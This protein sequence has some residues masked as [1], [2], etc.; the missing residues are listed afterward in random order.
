MSRRIALAGRV[1]A[2]ATRAEARAYGLRE[3]RVDV[4]DAHVAG[5]SMGGFVAATL[6]FARP[7]LV[8]SLL[9]SDAVGEGA[10]RAE[11]PAR[12]AADYRAFLDRVRAAEGPV[13]DARL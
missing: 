13:L 4:G 11:V 3:R 2:A 7:D 6:A 9:L 1:Y 12:S 8:R 10:V 5:S